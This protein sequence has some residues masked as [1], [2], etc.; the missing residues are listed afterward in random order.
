MQSLITIGYGNRSIDDFALLLS[1]NLVA[2][3]VDVR[4]YPYSKYSPDFNREILQEKIGF[5]GVRY[6]FMGDSLGGRPNQS[7]FFGEDGKVDYLEAEKSSKFLGGIERLKK[8]VSQNLRLALM[9]S[10]LKPEQCH[11]SKLIGRH[12]CEQGIDVLHVDENGHLLTQQQIVNRLT[13]GQS[14]LFGESV[15]ITRSRAAYQSVVPKANKLWR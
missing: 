3:L 5:S 8:A 9:C 6:V 12:L 11:R 2:Y 13:G 7:N 15:K 1:S 10:E 4:S 14:D